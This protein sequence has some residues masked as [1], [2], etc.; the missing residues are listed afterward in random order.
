[1][2][3]A[4]QEATDG[5]KFHQDVVFRLALVQGSEK[6]CVPMRVEHI[7]RYPVKGLSRRRAGGGDPHPRPV[8]AA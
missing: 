5:T 2:P 3:P 4:P 6:G 1:M 7:Y 8:P